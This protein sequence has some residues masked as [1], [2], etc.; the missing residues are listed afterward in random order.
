MSFVSLTPWTGHTRCRCFVVS[1]LWAIANLATGSESDALAANAISVPEGFQVELLYSAPLEEQ[2]SWV[3][4]TADD[5]GRLIVSDE[6]GT[7]YRVTP[8]SPGD[9]TEVK[10]LTVPLGYAQGLLFAYDSL[11]V[12]VNM[13]AATRAKEE[14]CNGIYRYLDTDGDDQFDNFKLLKK[15]E[16]EGSHGPHGLQLGPDGLI[17]VIAGNNTQP[18]EE[19]VSESP[20]RN[21]ADD[22]LVSSRDDRPPGGWVARTDPQ[23]ENWELICGG[24]RNPYDIDFNQ[25]GALFTVDADSESDIGTAWYRPTRVNHI[26]S[27]GEYGWRY[28]AGEWVHYGKWPAYYPDSVGSVVDF[29][30]GSPTGITFGTGAK[31]PAKYQRAL[32][33]G[34]W[35]WGRIY[36][37][38]VTPHGASYTAT[39]ETFA[40]GKPLP[41]T[42]MVI[43][44]DGA[45]Y[46]ITGGRSTQTGL[47]RV[48]YLEEKGTAPVGPV[49][50]PSTAQKRRIRRELERYHGKRDAIAIDKAWPFLGCADRA[51]RYA[52]R[53]AIEHQDIRL[54]HD[55]ALD[56]RRPSTSI[57]ALLA[58]VRTGDPVIQDVVL[59]QLNRLP[60]SKLTEGQLLAALRVY[61]LAFVRLGGNDSRMASKVVSRLDPFFPN[62]S[63]PINRELCRLLIYL[64]A[65]GVVER[66]LERLRIA[67]TQGNQMFYVFALSDLKN[68]WRLD[69]R[70]AFFSWL[71]LA[72]EKYRSGANELDRPELDGRFTR[73]IQRYR[74]RVVDQLNDEEMLAL[75]DV[76]EGREN[77]DVVDLEATRRPIFNWQMAD[78]LPRLEEVEND[79]LFENGR[80]AYRAAQCDKCHR[81][82]WEGGTTGPDLTG[83]GNR[84]SPLYILEALLVPSKVIPDTYQN[85]V[86]STDDGRVITGRIIANNG[87]FL[88]VRTH[89]FSRELIE[90][91]V[92]EVDAL[93]PSA[94]SEM[95]A[96]LV[97]VLTQ[98][99]IF[100][101]IAYLRTNHRPHGQPG[102]VK[103]LKE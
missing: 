8:G 85:T 103:Q 71:N 55:R 78:L 20:L 46:F 19:F 68:G 16:G 91:A 99:E 92:A 24:L 80:N 54:W 25:E 12:T 53:V 4:M 93:H 37:V 76:I 56:E 11:F 10:K 90:I 102:G 81:L 96:G 28:D 40:S 13:N 7:L 22:L 15:L 57:Q 45:M 39:Y 77:T 29:G 98:E 101:L 52:A 100:D 84:F 70:K 31:F 58:L 33:S 1:I 44:H 69:Q 64:Q 63:E 88:Q 87:G 47:Y 32:F 14:K 3:S 9:T 50:D 95:P 17:Y 6:N 72:E 5:Q 49:V 30:V 35:A 34:D 73:L 89:P 79:R 18:P 66:S 74:Q 2:G 83:V 42:D 23:G 67:Q 26:V 51:L 60:L 97:N 62:L 61:A 36:A 59:Q 38:S 27:A 41:V 82:D 65:P 21:W 48:S 43:N 86:I 75:S 94:V